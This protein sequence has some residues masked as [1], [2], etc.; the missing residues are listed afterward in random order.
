MSEWT[1]YGY[2]GEGSSPAE[3][4]RLFEEERSYGTPQRARRAAP[5][6]VP[7]YRAPSP[8]EGAVAHCDFETRSTVDLKKSG[9]YRYA[10]DPSTEILC[11]SWCVGDEAVQSWAPGEPDPRPLLDHICAGGV[12][13]AHNAGFE[14]AI[15]NAKTPNW[16]PRLTP[17]GQDCTMARAV[18]SA[19]PAGL[20]Q[21]GTALKLSAQKDK[22]GHRLMMQLC[23]PR[24]FEGDTPIWWQS[25]SRVALRATRRSGGRTK[26]S[27][28]G[29]ASTASETWK[30]NERRERSCRR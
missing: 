27:W 2:Q 22:D 13:V 30:P 16:W 3:R 9:V 10:E 12:V 5:Q 24:R 11:M 6:P 28:T 21:L 26:R 20:D 25:A 23:K 14:R 7:A 18:V 15:W 19:L 17:E 29:S 1:G 4:L 8:R